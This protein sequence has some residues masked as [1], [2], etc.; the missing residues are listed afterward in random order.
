MAEQLTQVTFENKF[1]YIQLLHNQTL[2][3]GSYGKVCKAKCDDLLCAAKI[4][5]PTLY[6]PTIQ[7]TVAAEREY[8]LPLQ[9]FEQECKVMCSMKHPNIVQYLG[10]YH[11]LTGTNLPVLLMELMNSSLN[12]F[13]Q[14]SMQPISYHTQVN[15]CHDITLALSFLHANNIIHRDLSSNNVLLTVGSIRAKVTDFGMARLGEL[16]S[17]MS[18]VTFT[19]CPGT[20][21]YMPPEAVQTNPVYTEKIDCFSFGVIAIQV[22][23]RQFPRPGDRHK[24]IEINDYRFPDGTIEVRVS[25]VERRQNHISEIEP[26]HPLLPIALDCLKD[27]EVERPSAHQLCERI[28]S[29]KTSPKYCESVRDAQESKRN[30]DS[31]AEEHSNE[32]GSQS[33]QL[34]QDLQQIIRSQRSRLEEKDLHISQ[35]RQEFEQALHQHR[36]DN[37]TMKQKETELAIVNQ[38][39][40]MSEQMK[41][42]HQRNILELERQLSQILREQSQHVCTETSSSSTEKDREEWEHCSQQVHDLQQLIQS[43]AKRLEE[44]AVMIEQKGQSIK[45]LERSVV[46]KDQIISQT[47]ELKDQLVLVK[48]QEVHKLRQQIRDQDRE[49]DRALGERTSQLS[50]VSQQLEISEQAILQ[51]QRRITELE[52]QLS[53]RDHDQPQAQQQP[54]DGSSKGEQFASIPLS[55]R[56]REGRRAPREMCRWSD[57]VV[58][59]SAVYIRVFN[60]HKVYTYIMPSKEWSRLPDSVYQNCP[61]VII[62]GLLTTIGGYYHGYFNKLVSLTGKGGEKRWTEIL[63][64]MP[65]KRSG[66]TALNSGTQLIVAGG[67][68]KHGKVVTVE[69]M[70]I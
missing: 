55:L 23:T 50:Y 9:R 26:N 39:L 22:L 45:Q 47:N 4:L 20:D 28:E 19:M 11:D 61:I 29:L 41:V 32:E 30:R 63:P 12:Q 40:E 64:P 56:W 8:R 54:E 52:E 67:E 2:G 53:L 69:A 10:L 3:I 27:K 7:Q 33:A 24:K 34:V 6:D 38:Q 60:T 46:I 5:H 25:E 35:L 62:N 17:Q 58:N 1:K 43:Q 31:N 16:T 44:K 37:E 14:G 59:G 66:S 36:Q 48:E 21:V 70:N 57:A 42:Q 13:L 51:F 18:Q 49:K 68:T 65:S 15:L